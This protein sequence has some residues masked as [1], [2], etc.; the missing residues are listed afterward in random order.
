[1][2]RNALCTLFVLGLIGCTGTFMEP[3][4]APGVVH[5]AEPEKLVAVISSEDYIK[6]CYRREYYF[7]PGVGGPLHRIEILKDIGFK[8]T[9]DKK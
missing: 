5:Q 3:P 8:N 7:C 6:Q 4:E 2:I 9:K 1:M